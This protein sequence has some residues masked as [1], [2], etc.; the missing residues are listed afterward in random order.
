MLTLI[1]NGQNGVIEGRGIEVQSKAPTE[2]ALV[3]HN[4][5][6]PWVLVHGGFPPLEQRGRNAGDITAVWAHS[7]RC[8]TCGGCAATRCWC[9]TA[10]CPRTRPP[11]PQLLIPRLLRGCEGSRQA[12]QHLRRLCSHPLLV[13]DRSLPTHAAAVAAAQ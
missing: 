11:W 1:D 4:E 9:W 2:D 12:L 6:T 13:L 3:H 8:S 5:R 10:A 7:R